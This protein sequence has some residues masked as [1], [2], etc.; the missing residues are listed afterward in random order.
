MPTA[1]A[2]PTPA[3][4]PVATG[5]SGNGGSVSGS[6]TGV[7]S[8]SGAAVTSG[9]VS[10]GFGSAGLDSLRWN[11]TEMLAAGAP[12][13]SWVG[14]VQPDGSWTTGDSNPVTTVDA[15]NQTLT[16]KFAWG[17][18]TYAYTATQTQMFANVTIQ[19]GS[20]TPVGEFIMQLAEIEFPSTPKEY[21]GS[22]PMVGW[23]MGNPTIIPATF[24]EGTGAGMGA[25]MLDVTD[26]DVVNPLMVGWPWS[27]N[28]A[29]TIF[30]LLVE[31]GGN[32][33][34]PS[35]YPCINR[36]IPA[37][38][39]LRFTI[40]FR[41]GPAGSTK[42]QLAGDVYQRFAAAFP[43]TLKWTD[44]RPIA[45]LFLA[46]QNGTYATNP[47]CWFGDSSVD[48]TTAAGIAAFQE[49]VLAYAQQAVAI[50]QGENAQAAITWDIEG[51]QFPQNT[52]YIGDPRLIGTLDP[53]MSGVVDAYFKTFTNAGI[54]VGMTIRPQQLVV[55]GSGSTLG[56]YQ[57]EVADPGALM[58]E[59]MSYAY[60]RWGATV[61]YVD[62]NGAP[63]CPMDPKFF[64][65]VA[66]ALPNVLVIPEHANMEY[67]SITA[68]YG[69]LNMGVTG[70]P[71]EITAVYPKAF[72]VFTISDGDVTGNMGALVSSVERGDA[73]FF[74]GWFGANENA[75]V[76]QI[77]QEAGGGTK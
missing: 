12:A 21:D 58:I 45:Q 3:G 68:P 73:L 33:M 44:R 11:G 51:E 7:V 56:A 10:M 76:V 50:C 26:E 34:L 38:G 14:L 1:V 39:T 75:E 57:E 70:T 15:G 41:F 16:Q 67:Y 74:R 59:K 5:S 42:E 69:Q 2:T 63:D 35:S 30:P 13:I 18:I 27:L 37:G 48:T 43:Q 52:T 66:A 24:G 40:G 25:G 65:A 53:E 62:S 55:S 36:Q 46:S 8:G 28:G 31:T 64:Q 60:Q 32:S 23:G 29:K 77:Y 22:D 71:A 47:R 49:R 6:G 61:F 9:T 72:S 54:R 19:N 17:S 4:T 20:T